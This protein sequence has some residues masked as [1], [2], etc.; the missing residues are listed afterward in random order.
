MSILK[1]DYSICGKRY[2]KEDNVHYWRGNKEFNEGEFI[3]EVD[4]GHKYSVIMS[5]ANFTNDRLSSV[6]L[7]FA[8]K[9]VNSGLAV[10]NDFLIGLKISDI[11][12]KRVHLDI[13]LDM[14]YKDGVLIPKIS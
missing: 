13:Y 10:D 3:E 2:S 7:S 8:E 14:N 5:Y 12:T 6:L 9:E 4:F 11:N 1:I